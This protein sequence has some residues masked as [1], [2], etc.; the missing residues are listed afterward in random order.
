VI[1]FTLLGGV[2]IGCLMHSIAD[3]MTVDPRGIA[4]LW[5]LKRRGV[6]LLPR[7]ARVWVGSESLSEWAFAAVWIAFV[8]SYVYVRF[9]TQLT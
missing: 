2:A 4:L 3:S 6:H 5:P 1:V 8:L 9:G 7:W